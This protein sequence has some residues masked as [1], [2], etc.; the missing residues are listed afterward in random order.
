MFIKKLPHLLLALIIAIMIGC[1]ASNPLVDEAQSHLE[2]QDYEQALAAAEKSIEQHPGDPMGYYFKAVALSEIAGTQEDPRERTEHYKE[3]NEAFSTARSIADTSESVPDEINRIDDVKNVLW[4][5][6]HNRAIEYIQSDSLKNTVDEPTVYSM[7]HLENATII[8]PDSSLSWNVYAQV[9]AMNKEFEKAVEAKEKYISMVPDTSVSPDDY[10]Q[11]A[12]YHFNLEN[13]QKVLEVFEKAQEQYPENDTIIENLADAYRRVGESDKA[14]AI[15]EKLVE[16]NPEDPQYNLVLGTQIYQRALQ[17]T[18]T[19]E[20]NSEKVLSL[21]KEFNEASPEEKKEI[22]E[23][24]DQLSQENKELQ[25]K[26]EELTQR[27]EDALQTTIE[28]RPDDADAYNTLGVIYQNRARTFFDRRNQTTDNEEAQEF[29][30]KGQ[31]LLKESMGYYEKA[32][33]IDPDNTEYWKRLFEI[34]TTLG[35]DEKAKEAMQKAGMD[36]QEGN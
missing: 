7:N 27:A 12:S 17:Y 30:E 34:Y 25:S 31:D 22:K 13:Q 6:E 10:M 29:H 3:M 32:A 11:L 28:H 36:D 1:S 16:K 26:V 35:M 9:S 21:Q 33:E 14:I 24:I 15:V 4:Q 19:L 2:S 20:T 23:Q 5:T 8:Q 18:D